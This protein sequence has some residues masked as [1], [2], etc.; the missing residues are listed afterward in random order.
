MNEA[1]IGAGLG[2][3]LLAHA[4]A[5]GHRVAIGLADGDVACRILIEQGVVEDDAAP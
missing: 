1:R 5:I 3:G 2:Q 4:A